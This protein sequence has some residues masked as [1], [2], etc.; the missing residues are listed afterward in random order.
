MTSHRVVSSDEWLAARLELLEKEK[1]FSRLRD[2]L[3]QLRRDLPWEKVEKQYPFDGPE[4]KESLSDL[5]GECSQLIIYHFMFGPDWPEGC[6]ICSMLADHYDPLVLH[7]KHRDV[8]LVTVSRAALT[9]LRAFQQRMGWRFK[10]VSSLENDFNWDFHV[11]FTPEAMEAKSV[12][13]N[14]REGAVF[15]ANEGPGVSSFYKDEDGDVFHTYSAYARGLENLLGVYNFLD[16]V[17]KG[18][19]EGGLPYGMAWV[20]HHDQY[21]DASVI[22]PYADKVSRQS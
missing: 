13:Y 3:T 21:T 10:W 4:G 8:A 6:K 22:D 2:E 7:L 16:L 20:R 19:D 17:P 12:Y 18:R 15:P 5:F 11:S 1:E 14:Y 9:T